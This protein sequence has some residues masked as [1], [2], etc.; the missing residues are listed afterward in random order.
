M[1]VRVSSLAH[2]QQCSASNL[3][4]TPSA[5]AGAFGGAATNQRRPLLGSGGGHG[6]RTN[7]DLGNSILPPSL[8][9]ITTTTP[10]GSI[11]SSNR[12]PIS[13]SSASFFGDDS[14]DNNWTNRNQQQ[15]KNG[16]LASGV[17]VGLIDYDVSQSI[18]QSPTDNVSSLDVVLSGLG[19]GGLCSVEVPEARGWVGCHLLEG[20]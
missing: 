13:G 10:S 20:R 15:L 3:L 7:N 12:W 11:S 5:S 4:P 8:W 9:P 14:G 6:G 17:G 1:P 18:D 19:V 16:F 2:Q